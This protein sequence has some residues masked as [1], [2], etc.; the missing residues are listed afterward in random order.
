V[1]NHARTLL[2]NLDGP[3]RPSEP[4]EDFVPSGFRAVTLTPGMNLVRSVLFGN[5]PDRTFLNY[6]LRQLLTVLHSTELEEYV[7]AL[8]PRITYWPNDNT[9]LFAGN[10]RTMASR[11]AGNPCNITFGGDLAADDRTGRCRH[12]WIVAIAST[13][14]ATITRTVAPLATENVSFT[15]AN[16]ITP[17][18]RLP[19]SGVTLQLGTGT[20]TAGL[21]WFNGLRLH[22]DH[23]GRPQVDL[24]MLEAM[25]RQSLDRTLLDGLFYG[26]MPSLVEPYTT[27]KNL[28]DSHPSLPYR[29]GGLLLAYIYRIEA[30]RANG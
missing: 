6:R 12:G 13:G 19:G 20:S 7:L 30:I 2:L 16:G 23:V 28:W 24:G 4:G 17:P 8:D 29:L 21:D 18:I 1:I 26:T 5:S 10:F 11:L 15:L 9:W 22:I 27:F 25:L 14:V 3:W